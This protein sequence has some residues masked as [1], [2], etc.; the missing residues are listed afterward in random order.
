MAVA[1]ET[2]GKAGAGGTGVEEV[3]LVSVGGRTG[4]VSGFGV[5]CL[6]SVGRMELIMS[7]F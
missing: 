5:R 2:G 4:G 7:S 6:R 1:T 3:S